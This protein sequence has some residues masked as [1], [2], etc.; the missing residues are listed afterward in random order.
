MI[1]IVDDSGVA[2]TTLREYLEPSGYQMEMAENGA[3]AWEMLSRSPEKYHAV[4]LDRVM[5]EMDG[6]EVLKK[7]KHH[8]SL[9]NLPVIM[10]TASRENHEIKEGIRAGAYY[11]L[12][13]PYSK[14]AVRLITSAAV[15]DFNRYRTPRNGPVNDL[16]HGSWQTGNRY[17]FRTP[18]EAQILTD[19][20]SR[21]CP[22]PEKV[23]AG[24][25]ELVLNAVEHGNLGITYSEK[26]RLI[27][28]GMWEEEVR[29]RF[30][31]PRYASRKATVTIE[32][33]A[34]E[35]RFRV[36][37]EGDGFDWTPYLEM[38]PER[39][40]DT[41]GRG[42]AMS[43]HRSFHRLEY[44]GNGNEVVAAVKI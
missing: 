30:T 1:L 15:N 22:S 7:M 42:I 2:R 28:E 10:Q 16:N 27:E 13:K 32:K 9:K 23:A 18:E 41:H 3:R 38:S 36:K 26:T 6:M 14:E 37:D 5:P 33:T 12:T 20:L 25:W 40:F 24:L 31:I 4:L 8:D 19:V 44:L 29:H 39:V 34:D 43:R 35:I 11:Y 21:E 17:H